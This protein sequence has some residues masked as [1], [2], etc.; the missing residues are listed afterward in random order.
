MK[1]HHFEII[2]KGSDSSTS[3][4]LIIPNHQVSPERGVTCIFS[5]SSTLD[6]APT[7]PATTRGVLRLH[8][9][10]YQ[11]KFPGK[12]RITPLSRIQDFCWRN[13]W[14]ITRFLKIIIFIMILNKKD[15]FWVGHLSELNLSDDRRSHPNWL[16]DKIKND[17]ELFQSD[18][19]TRWPLNF[20]ILRN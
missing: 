9:F 20:K 13:T 4:K 8:L 6:S 19:Y 11:L 1:T 14:F 15:Y 18:A 7:R 16:K 5:I 2:F 3:P 10:W 17:L 12:Y